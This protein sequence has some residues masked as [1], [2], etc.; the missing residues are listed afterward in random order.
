MCWAIDDLYSSFD[1]NTYDNLQTKC[2]YTYIRG[3]E[4]LVAVVR[5]WMEQGR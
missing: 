2:Y 4:S 1:Y 3:E 5:V